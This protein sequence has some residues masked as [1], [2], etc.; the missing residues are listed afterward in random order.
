M[1]VVRSLDGTNFTNDNH[2]QGEPV[3]RST[4]GY[5]EKVW[6]L[7]DAYPNKD[8][9]D[10]ALY[11]IERALFR[12]DYSALRYAVTT[13]AELTREDGTRPV[14]PASAWFNGEQYKLYLDSDE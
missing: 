9:E 7:F 2:A 10:K 3:A 11:A 5:A 4:K 12:M 1:S 6:D 14:P 13:F 8:N